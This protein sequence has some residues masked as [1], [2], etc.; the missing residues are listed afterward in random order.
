VKEIIDEKN[1][2]IQYLI[3]IVNK[4]EYS[5]KKYENQP[6]ISRQV[7]QYGIENF[8]TEIKFQGAED[9]FLI[10]KH[11]DKLKINSVDF[12]IENVLSKEFDFFKV[13]MRPHVGD[14]ND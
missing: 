8:N 3:F 5:L 12:D 1:A 7:S 11:I 9:L 13:L 4:L 10:K 14:A 2:Y 6:L